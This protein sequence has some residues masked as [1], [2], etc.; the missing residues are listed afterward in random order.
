M[1]G[2]IPLFWAFLCLTP[3]QGFAQVFYEDFPDTVGT[4]LTAAGWTQSGTSSVNPIVVS[5]PGGLLYSGYPCSGSGNAASLRTNGQDVYRAFAPVF[6]GGIY[7]SFMVNVGVA[8]TGDYFLALSPSASQLSYTARV[9]AKSAP[10]GFFLGLSKTNEAASGALY[11]SSVFSYDTTYLVIV[12]YSFVADDTTDDPVSL[13]AFSDPNLPEEEPAVA[14]VGP[15]VNNQKRDAVNLGYITLRQG[16]LGV[17]PALVI[18]GIRVATAWGDAAL[19]VTLA[20][21]TG[22][23]REGSSVTLEWSTVSEIDNYGFEVQRSREASAGF[24]TIS[25]LIPG[26]GTT[27]TCHNYAYTDNPV[28]AGTWFYRLKQ[29]DRDNSAHMSEAIW[30]DVSVASARAGGFPLLENYPNPFNSATEIGF[31]VQAGGRGV[32]RIYTMLGQLVTTPFEG[33]VKSAEYH[34]VRFDGSG[35][36]SGVYICRLEC[37]G[38]AV[39][40]KLI[41]EK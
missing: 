25:G 1:K 35:L 5:T 8:Q 15:Y 24:E 7:V 26:Y 19:P 33:E 3:P 23:C 16:T 29:T 13:F 6:S 27:Q 20:S 34:R 14:E 41:L 18:D 31:S 30:V 38:R 11:G 9:F 39:S 32:L 22:V 21:F 17:A 28:Q 10:G 4:A 37:G 12:K 40:R 2:L 36:A